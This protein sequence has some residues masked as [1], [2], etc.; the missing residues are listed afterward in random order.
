MLGS[1][2][3]AGVGGVGNGVVGV[4]EGCGVDGVPDGRGVVGYGVVGMVV[5]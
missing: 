5:G 1:N 4:A 3:G 2:A